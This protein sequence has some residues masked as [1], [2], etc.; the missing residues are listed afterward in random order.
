MPGGAQTITPG[1]GSMQLQPA[2]MSV[3]SV[4]PPL[5]SADAVSPEETAR[6]DCWP[7]SAPCIC[8]P[9]GIELGPNGDEHAPIP[10]V[11]NTA[12][13]VYARLNTFDMLHL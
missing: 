12:S 8:L 6:A 5:E 2:F 4:T 1:P 11:P 3:T 13:K 9:D 7:S 10:K